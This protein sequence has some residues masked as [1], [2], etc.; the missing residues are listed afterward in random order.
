[1]PRAARARCA[2]MEV[3]L[4]RCPAE[5]GTGKLLERFDAGPVDVYLSR[6]DGIGCRS[7]RADPPSMELRGHARNI[8]KTRS[9]PIRDPRLIDSNRPAA[10]RG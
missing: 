3:R 1:M 5:V 7:S 2:D 4:T 9:W 10:V 6:E 8:A